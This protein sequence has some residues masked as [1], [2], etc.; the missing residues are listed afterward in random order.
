[1]NK[2]EF[3]YRLNQALDTFG[4]A[5][6]KE[7]LGYYEELIQDAIEGGADEEEFIDKLG[8]IDKIIR[9]VKKDSDFV[10]NVKQKKNFQLKSV[11]DDSVRII[12]HLI[13][14]FVIFIIGT[15]A[16]SIVTGG[17]SLAFY[18]LVEGLQAIVSALGAMQI[19]MQFGLMLIGL[20]LVITGVAIF[21]WMIK[22]SR[23]KLEKLLETIQGLIK[24][25]GK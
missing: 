5:E 25:V 21:Q 6:K 3:L 10:E 16:F 7:I 11:I 20:G 2:Y 22:E 15:V 12:G 24:K 13:F 17:A 18:G 4:A 14:F 23:G 8:S 19:A 1:M 9:T